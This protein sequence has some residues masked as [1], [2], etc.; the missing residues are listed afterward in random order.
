MDHITRGAHRLYQ[1][2][3]VLLAER[4]ILV[5]KYE[6]FVST[7]FFNILN[8]DGVIDYGG[9]SASRLEVLE[10]RLRDDVI[11]ELNKFGG[12]YALKGTED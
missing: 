9:I 7:A 6:G 11:A 5:A 8:A 12:R 10:E 4:G 2:L 3:A 1:W